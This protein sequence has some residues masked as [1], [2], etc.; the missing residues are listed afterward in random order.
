MLLPPLPLPAIL[1]DTRRIC[2]PLLNTLIDVVGAAG[3]GAAGVGAAG[4]GAV[5]DED[6]ND[7]DAVVLLGTPALVPSLWGSCSI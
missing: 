5:T 6:D 4:V 2:L 3:V 1:P 7:D